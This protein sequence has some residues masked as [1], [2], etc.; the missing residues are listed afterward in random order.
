MLRRHQCYSMLGSYVRR[1]IASYQGTNLL[2]DKGFCH[3][4]TVHLSAACLTRRVVGRQ[5]SIRDSRTDH[6]SGDEAR[7]LSYGE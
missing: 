5:G 3:H 1:C 7:L 2:R 6:M 4:E